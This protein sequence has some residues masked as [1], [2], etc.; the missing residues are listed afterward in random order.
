MLSKLDPLEV[1]LK[2]P[3]VDLFC[4]EVGTVA[5][6]AISKAQVE[7]NFNYSTGPKV[8][9]WFDFGNG[10]VFMVIPTVI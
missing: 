2:C 10:S 8:C 5:G 6:D 4:E 9:G 7:V 1:V 3:V